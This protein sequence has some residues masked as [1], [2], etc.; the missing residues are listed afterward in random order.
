MLSSIS[1]LEHVSLLQTSG[2][3]LCSSEISNVLD[4]V[5]KHLPAQSQEGRVLTQLRDCRTL[6]VRLRSTDSAYETRI[7]A[8]SDAML[9]M[10]YQIREASRFDHGTVQ[11]FQTLHQLSRVQKNETE[12]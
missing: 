3:S 9:A 7:Y 2:G 8:P 6:L 5:G 12:S 1:R 11:G 4:A 10:D